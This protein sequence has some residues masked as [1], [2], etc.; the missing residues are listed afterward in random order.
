M[1]ATA[2]SGLARVAG[3]VLVLIIAA[4]AGM[5]VGNVL[6]ERVDTAAAGA[7][8]SGYVTR[9]SDGTAAAAPRPN[10]SGYVTDNPGGTIVRSRT[11]ESGFSLRVIEQLNRIRAN[12]AAAAD[13]SDGDASDYGLRHPQLAPDPGLPG[14]GQRKGR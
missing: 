3:V 9:D 6:R 4:A 13:A 2:A 12:E 5:A 14:T 7:N 1:N 11:A 8:V 10:T